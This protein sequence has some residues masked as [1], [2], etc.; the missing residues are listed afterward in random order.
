VN[1]LGT[2]G[3]GDARRGKYRWGHVPIAPYDEGQLDALQCSNQLAKKCLVLLIVDL[4][5]IMQVNGAD[6][7]APPE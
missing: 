4:T 3:I 7:D 2:Q 1:D 5:A 6:D